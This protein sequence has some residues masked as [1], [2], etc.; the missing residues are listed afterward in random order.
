MVKNLI[1]LLKLVN[2][3]YIIIY[4]DIQ[5]RSAMLHPFHNSFVIINKILIDYYTYCHLKILT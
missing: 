4:A 2:D 5:Q 1:V 3:N